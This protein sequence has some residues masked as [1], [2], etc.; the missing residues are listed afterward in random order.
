MGAGEG[1]RREGR[2]AGISALPVAQ[3]PGLGGNPTLGWVDVLEGGARLRDEVES[4]GENAPDDAGA[5]HLWGAAVLAVTIAGGHCGRG[6]R[7]G[8][9]VPYAEHTSGAG[10]RAASGWLGAAHAD[11]D[12]IP[13]RS[14]GTDAHVWT[15]WCAMDD[16]FR[17]LDAKLSAASALQCAETRV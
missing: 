4:E 9:P 1:R 6:S 5:L 10:F 17:F 14:A 7:V 15:S 8:A 2:L 12:P 13:L 3:R 11:G 16:V